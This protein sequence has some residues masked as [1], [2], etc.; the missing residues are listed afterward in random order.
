M[1]ARNGLGTNPPKAAVV[2]NKAGIKLRRRLGKAVFSYKDFQDEIGQ[3]SHYK[4]G[5]ILPSDYCYN[6]VNSSAI[7][8]QYQASR[9]FELYL[10]L[11][12]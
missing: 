8:F 1:K 3:I 4:K 9:I 12:T 7:S 2:A 10:D 5:S 11:G 6:L